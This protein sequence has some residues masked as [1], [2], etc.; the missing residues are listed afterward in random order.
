MNTEYTPQERFAQD[1]AL[2]L[3]NDAQAYAKIQQRAKE[4]RKYADS[5]AP[6]LSDFI[7]QLVEESVLNALK[8]KE[9]L[10]TWLIREVMLGWGVAP[11]D[12]M[13]RD[14]LAELA[15][16]EPIYTLEKENSFKIRGTYAEVMKALEEA[17]A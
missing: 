7:R 11:Y 3:D 6:K 13:A 4:I 5:S 2:V 16:H 14:I 8:D 15:E 12:L 1:I 10:G 9:T 17:S